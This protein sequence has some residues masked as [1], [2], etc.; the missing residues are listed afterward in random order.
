VNPPLLPHKRHMPRP[1]LLR[2][3]NV[4]KSLCVGIREV[5][6]GPHR[7]TYFVRPFCAFILARRLVYWRSMCNVGRVNWRQSFVCCIELALRQQL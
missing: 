7:A 1:S 5:A 4:T 6:F 2:T 3:E